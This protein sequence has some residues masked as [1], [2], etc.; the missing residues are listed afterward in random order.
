MS[1]PLNAL[2]AIDQWLGSVAKSIARESSKVLL[3]FTNPH[4]E[5]ARARRKNARSAMSTAPRS[6]P[7]KYPSATTSVRRSVRRS[8]RRS[9]PT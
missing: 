6:T 9:V 7:K 2:A 8:A 3:D 5:R 4:R 1:N